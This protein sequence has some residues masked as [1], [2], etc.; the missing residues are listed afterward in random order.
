MGLKWSGCSVR[1][2]L[3]PRLHHSCHRLLSIPPVYSAAKF[4]PRPCVRSPYWRSGLYRVM[5]ASRST[6][7]PSPCYCE[8]W[9]H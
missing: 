8:C 1:I 3:W 2:R 4:S 5:R 9:P 7:T 6:V